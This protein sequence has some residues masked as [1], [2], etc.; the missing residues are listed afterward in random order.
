MKM[1]RVLCASCGLYRSDQNR[2]TNNYEVSVR[3]LNVAS[4][5]DAVA[6]GACFMERNPIGLARNCYPYMARGQTNDVML[7]RG[8]DRGRYFSSSNNFAAAA[9]IRDR[10][11]P[12]VDGAGIRTGWSVVNGETQALE[13]YDLDGRIKTSTA[14]CGQVTTFAYSVWLIAME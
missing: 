1:F 9:D 7:R 3:D 2:W 10:L 8:F 14:L 11:T 4:A 12:V 6:Q 13:N 5:A